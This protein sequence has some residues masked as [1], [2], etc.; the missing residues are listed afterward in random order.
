MNHADI[1]IIG[2]VTFGIISGGYALIYSMIKDGIK[3]LLFFIAA[4]TL[5]P[6]VI[7]ALGFLVS[8]FL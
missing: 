5:T 1:F 6:M 2:V 7:Y 4:I 3:P 8:L